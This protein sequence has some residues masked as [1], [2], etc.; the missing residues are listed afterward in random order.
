MP[1]RGKSC[2]ARAKH[3]ADDTKRGAAEARWLRLARRGRDASWRPRRRG[4]SRRPLEVAPSCLPC[5]EF[6]S[7]FQPAVSSVSCRPVC[8]AAESAR[9]GERRCSPG[10][11]P[12]WLC[13]SLRA[14]FLLYTFSFLRLIEIRRGRRDESTRDADGEIGVYLYDKRLINRWNERNQG[15]YVMR[16]FGNQDRTRQRG[17]RS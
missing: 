5:S 8:R 14:V 17:V 11:S 7:V 4:R 13:A 2:L 12:T 6:P 9:A 15:R 3:G 1:S 16:I 10:D